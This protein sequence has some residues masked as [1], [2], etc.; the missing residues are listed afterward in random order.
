MGDTNLLLRA[1]RNGHSKK[2][3]LGIR[4]IGL[5]TS[6]I[7]TGGVELSTDTAS[8]PG[9]NVWVTTAM[10]IILAL[11]PIILKALQA[12][13][14]AGYPI[15]PMSLNTAYTQPSMSSQLTQYLPYIIG[16]IAIYFL[17]NKKH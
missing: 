12:K 4:A 5:D 10:T 6:G 1:I 2:A 3:L 14:A 15:N 8:I 16:G 7:T 9:V 17:M 11:A 13:Q